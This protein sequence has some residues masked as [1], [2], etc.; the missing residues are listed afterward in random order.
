M[1]RDLVHALLG[2][3]ERIFHGKSMAADATEAVPNIMTWNH[4]TETEILWGKHRLTTVSTKNDTYVWHEMTCK[5]RWDKYG[6]MAVPTGLTLERILY[7]CQPVEPPF[8]LFDWPKGCTV[9]PHG[10]ITS[11]GT[12]R[13]SSPSISAVWIGLVL[14]EH[15]Y[16]ICFNIGN[17]VIKRQIWSCALS[18]QTKRLGLRRTTQQLQEVF[19]IILKRAS[20]FS[21][22]LPELL[23]AERSFFSPFDKQGVSFFCVSHDIIW[24]W[25]NTY[26]IYR[27][28]EHP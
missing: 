14:S 18:F 28:D 2:R 26:N 21:L 9:V 27:G 4:G 7:S 1:Q 23:V 25:I 16:L 20:P 19:T 3:D 22:L 24:L 5:Q 10:H 13:D 6:P 15:W 11:P 8:K 12:S 17:M